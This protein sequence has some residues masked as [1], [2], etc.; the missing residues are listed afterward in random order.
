MVQ[1]SV[2]YEY[3]KERFSVSCAAAFGKVSIVAAAGWLRVLPRCKGTC[4]LS[5][6]L[7]AATTPHD[8][9]PFLWPDI[10][11]GFMGRA[12]LDACCRVWCTAPSKRLS[13]VVISTLQREQLFTSY[14]QQ[15]GD[16]FLQDVDG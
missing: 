8:R 5:S 10:L 7:V 12:A 16:S 13:R 15:S 11:Q 14:R 2:E 6:L 1:S 3:F 9:K 4:L